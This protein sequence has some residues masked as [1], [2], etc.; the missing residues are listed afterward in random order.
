LQDFIIIDGL[1]TLL[2]QIRFELQS[3]YK[4]EKVKKKKYFTLYTWVYKKGM[5]EVILKWNKKVIGEL[6]IC[7]YLFLFAVVLGKKLF[8]KR[9]VL[10]LYNEKSFEFLVLYW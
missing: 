4:V 8:L 1:F 9:S 3:V 7:N 10:H 2:S 6:A 5:L